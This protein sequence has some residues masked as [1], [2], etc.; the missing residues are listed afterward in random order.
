MTTETPKPPAKPTL[1]VVRCGTDAS[2]APDAPGTEAVESPREPT[3]ADRCRDFLM[4]WS[5][6]AVR[7]VAVIVTAEGVGLVASIEHDDKVT[8]TSEVMALLELGR[9][10]A[11][12]NLEHAYGVEI[13]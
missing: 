13:E 9:R 6:H 7:F 8:E 2:D 10:S 5:Q 1:K 3:E 11:Q 4:H 12:V